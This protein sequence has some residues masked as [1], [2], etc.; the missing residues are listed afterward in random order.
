M[1]IEGRDGAGVTC[2]P[3]I[4]SRER[5]SQGIAALAFEV[6]GVVHDTCIGLEQPPIEEAHGSRIVRYH[7]CVAWGTDRPC[8]GA[9]QALCTFLFQ[10]ERSSLRSVGRACQCTQ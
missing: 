7:R 2:V 4:T 9:A 3:A 6:H 10:L 8:K 1:E 5:T